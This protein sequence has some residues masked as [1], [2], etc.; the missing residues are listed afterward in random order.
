MRPSLL[1]ESDQGFRKKIT[2][3]RVLYTIEFYPEEGKYH[4]N[5][6][7]NCKVIETPD[8]TR[9]KGVL[10]PI[11]KR[12]LTVGVMQRVED[13]SDE[14][15]HGII[16]ANKQGLRWIKDPKGNHPPFV[17]I[18]P[19]NE[20]IAESFGMQVGAGKVKTMFDLL[21]GAFGSEMEILLRASIE[22]IA[23]VSTKKIAEGVQS[24][25]AGNI[26]IRPGFDGE[27]GTVKI[28]R[29]DENKLSDKDILQYV[30]IEKDQ[31]GIDF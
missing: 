29:D 1:L 21:C 7:R 26:V 2:D 3:N 18:V 27:Y 25:R 6:H 8:E 19:L 20:I 4:Y 30:P 14:E 31:L 10:C 11:C 22:D 23:N 24:V 16:K 15:V 12:K 28:C 5:G 13:L 9:A 17:K